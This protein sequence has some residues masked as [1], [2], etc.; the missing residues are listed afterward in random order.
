MIKT[1][2]ELAA[3]CKKVATQYKTAYMLGCFG[4]PVTQ[5]SLSRAVSNNK[6]NAARP[7]W[8]SKAKAIEGEGF[9]FDCVNLI[10]A[11][12]W[13]WSGDKTKSYGGAKYASN[14]VPDIGADR[15]IG[16]CKDVSTTGWDSMCVGEA[17]WM[18]GHIGIYIGDGLAVECTPAFKS[19][20]QI[21]AVGNIGKQVG[22]STRT[23]TKHGKLPY[24][25]YEAA[26]APVK[27]LSPAKTDISIGDI[28]QF[29][30]G[31][32]YPSAG[33]TKGT[34]VKA[35]PAKVTALSA[36]SK[37]P[38]HIVHTDKT[39]AVYGWVDADKVS[40]SAG[41]AKKYK[42]V[43]AVGLNVRKG[44]GSSYAKVCAI[45]CGTVVEVSETSGGWGRVLAKGGWVS[46]QYLQEV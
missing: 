5:A 9:M 32:H 39:S 17:V 37:H 6:T 24:V 23:W 36:G 12:L 4:W 35:G 26:P 1:G 22:Y 28:V 34:T 20:V 14:G 19:G 41:T 44:P 3:A 42:V 30:G 2:A 29:A 33:S 10:K 27:P 21:T 16:V 46:M 11:L 18:K 15:M 8:Q 7:T 25:T 43:P 38:Y 40:I 45:P 13:G 31:Y